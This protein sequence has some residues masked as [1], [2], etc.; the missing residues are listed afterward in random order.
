M[1]TIG[2]LSAIVSLN[3]SDRKGEEEH[4]AFEELDGGVTAEFIKD[5]LELHTAVLVNGGV[6]IEFLSAQCS[7]QTLLGHILYIDLNALAAVF[8]ALVRLGQTSLSL[9]LCGLV[10]AQPA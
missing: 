4:H 7:H 1:E 10:Q 5:H 9:G 8:H 3:A 6:L 2:K